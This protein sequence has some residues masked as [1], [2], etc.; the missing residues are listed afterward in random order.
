[1]PITTPVVETVLST[2]FSPAGMAPSENSRLPEP[3]HDGEDPESVLVNQVVPQQR[4]DEIAAA[5]HLQFRPILFFERRE[6][7]SR[8]TLDQHRIAPI[9]RPAYCGMRRT[10]WRR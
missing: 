6:S 7:Y 5:V 4:L 8:I 2:S 9:Q 3:M 10:W 1:M